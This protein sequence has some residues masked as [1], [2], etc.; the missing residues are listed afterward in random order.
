MLMA[1]L[2]EETYTYHERLERSPLASRLVGEGLSHHFYVAALGIN[3]GFY[4]PLEARLLAIAGWDDLGFDL[5]ARLKTP[6]LASDLGH[7]GIEGE[8]L[9]ALPSCAS[10]PRLPDLSAA[11]GCMYVLEGATLGSQIIARHLAA[12]LLIGPASGAAFYSSYR[13]QVP[14]MWRAFKVFAENHGAGH[15]DAVIAAASAT[16]AALEAWYNESYH[17]IASAGRLTPSVSA[18]RL[19]PYAV[20]ATP[21][22]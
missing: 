2:R 8:L 5:A 10:L 3:Y 14:T 6:L 11:L 18:G 22:A 4:A 19:A 13:G 1:S 20:A 16:F 9:H 17:A 7:F 15:E 12:S 21:A